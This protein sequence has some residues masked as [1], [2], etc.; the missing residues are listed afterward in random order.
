MRFDDSLKTVLAAD[1]S[2]AFGAKATFRQ[3]VDLAARGRAPADGE[4]IERLRYLRGKVPAEV[5]GAAARGLALGRP[6]V[7]LVAFFAEDESMVAS[8]ALRAARL[9]NDDWI[10]LLPQLGPSGRAVLRRRKDLDPVVE[11]ALG[12][13]GAADFALPYD[14]R[15]PLDRPVAPSVGTSPFTPVGALTHALPVVA[16]ARRAAQEAPPAP[17]PNGGFDIAELVGRIQSYQLARESGAVPVAPV[18][19]QSFRFETGSDGVIQWTD[20]SPRGAIVGIALGCAL[21]D[22][23]ARVDGVAAG[24]FRRRSAFSDARLSVAGESP[25]AGEWRISAVPMF[26]PATGRFTGYRGTARRPRPDETAVRRDPTRSEGLRRLVHEL[27]TPTN[28]IAGFSELIETQLLGPVAPVYR[29]RAAAIRGQAADLVAA[30]EDLDLAA[31]IEGD[32]LELRPGEVPL[33]ELLARVSDELAPL[34][35]LRGATLAVPAIDEGLLLMCDDRAVER[36]FA[37]LLATVM[38]SAQQGE[39]IALEAARDGGASAT[40]AIDRP[41]ALANMS[42]EMLLNLDAEREADLPGAPLL[43]TGFALRLAC[44]LAAELGGKLSIGADRLRL[45]LPATALPDMDRASTN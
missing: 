34:A 29:E 17:L 38:S 25:S 2:T 18:L 32:A 26:D 28:A 24:A 30:I 23:A 8:A 22:G 6:P 19:Q 39:T 3:L 40:I 1:A 11:R 27:R 31:R 13:F 14:A 41:R 21:T 7:A 37:R 45:V 9:S 43:G 42:D 33:A 44:N 16:A 12:T 4:V 20:A 10:A 35:Q 15:A 36:L 5:R